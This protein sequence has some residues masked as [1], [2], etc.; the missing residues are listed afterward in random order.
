MIDLPLVE[1]KLIFSEKLKSSDVPELRGFFG[2]KFID[3]PLFHHHQPNG[4]Y[5]YSYPLVQY[6]LNVRPIKKPVDCKGNKFIGFMGNFKV[7]FELPDYI[8]LG[9]GVSRGFG[10][11]RRIMQE[12]KM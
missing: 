3:Q 10:T 8:G 12:R 7:N 9:K 4:G 5:I 6:K 1:I 2:R 11:V